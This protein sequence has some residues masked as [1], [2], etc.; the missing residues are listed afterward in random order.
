VNN[1]TNSTSSTLKSFLKPGTYN[2]FMPPS[3]NIVTR[4]S[5][6]FSCGILQYDD[7]HSHLS[8]ILP[9]NF[10]FQIPYL[11]PMLL[12]PSAFH[13]VSLF[14]ARNNIYLYSRRHHL[15]IISQRHNPSFIFET[16]YVSINFRSKLF[17]LISNKNGASNWN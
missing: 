5:Y 12:C 17:E 8:L 11:I 15:S 14:M 13:R 16:I 7:A 4:K 9:Y 2:I 3:A 6:C 10:C 1:K